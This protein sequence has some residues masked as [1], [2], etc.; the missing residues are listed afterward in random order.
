MKSPVM[1]VGL[2]PLPGPRS[3]FAPIVAVEAEV[4]MAGPA[5]A[6]RI[7]QSRASQ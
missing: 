3:A 6:F 2:F 7:Y 5:A 1:T 4:G